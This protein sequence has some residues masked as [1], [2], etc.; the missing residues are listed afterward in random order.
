[1]TLEKMYSELMDLYNTSGKEFFSEAVAFLAECF[2]GREHTILG[3]SEEDGWKLVSSTLKDADETEYLRK[4][5]VKEYEDNG[6]ESFCFTVQR[7]GVSSHMA[8]PLTVCRHKTAGVWVIERRAGE[9]PGADRSAYRVGQL[10]SFFLQIS[11]DERVRVFNRYLDAGMNLPG[12]LYFRQVAGR[13]QEQGHQ[14]ILCGFRWDKYREEVRLKGSKEMEEKLRQLVEKIASLELGNMYA[15][16]E[17]TI[18]VISIADRQEVYAR[19]ES[20]LEE[21][22]MGG[23]LKAVMMR[24]EPKQEILTEMEELFSMCTT[25]IIWYRMQEKGNVFTPFLEDFSAQTKEKI[26][27]A[28]E[29]GTKEKDVLMDEFLRTL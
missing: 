18:A 14:V 10:L 1:M 9:K 25:G 6:R 16:S 11:L 21:E 13:I 17:D 27:E 22:G 19:M 7:P 2:P 15:L 8:V 24:P 20:I 28:S 3:R 12:R 4:A 5:V 29:N 26:P 23:V